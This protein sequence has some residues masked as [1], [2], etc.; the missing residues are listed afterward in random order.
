MEKKELYEN[1]SAEVWKLALESGILTASTE[2]PE[3]IGY[4]GSF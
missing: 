4:G 2:E 1:P 3:D